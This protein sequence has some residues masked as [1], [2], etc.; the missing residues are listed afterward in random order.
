MEKEINKNGTI[1]KYHIDSLIEINQSY[2]CQYTVTLSDLNKANDYVQLI[3]RT[4]SDK[5]PKVGDILRYTDQ[6][7]NFYLNAHVEKNNGDE[8]N[9]CENIS[10]PFIWEDGEKGICCST[11]GGPWCNQKSCL[12]KYIGKRQKTFCDWG[13]YG[14][15]KN[16]AIYF[17]AE[18]SEWE[19]IH[20]EPLYENFTTEKWRK[21]CISYIPEKYRKNLNGYLYFG[22]GIGF[23]TEGEFQK[24]K[25]NFKAKVF[26]GYY[27]N[28]YIVWCYNEKQHNVTK[29]EFAALKF[30]IISIYCNGQHPAKI[31]YD[32]EN[33]IAITH[34]N[35]Y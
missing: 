6:N 14:P 16:G 22:D 32:D 35:L 13:H 17:T 2:N 8:C 9:I 24:F 19:Y 3:E 12:L 7:G 27:A 31:E 23:F 5:I 26:N 20:P 28:Q 15:S 11:S 21:L 10:T 33:K 34:F 30:P 18:V 29:T 1:G 4:R 25:D